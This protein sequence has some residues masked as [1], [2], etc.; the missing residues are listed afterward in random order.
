MSFFFLNVLKSSK[1][2]FENENL[3]FG[4]VELPLLSMHVYVYAKVALSK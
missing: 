3:K 4:Q 2:S 1:T